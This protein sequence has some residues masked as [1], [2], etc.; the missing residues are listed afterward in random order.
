MFFAVGFETTAP[1]NAMA[2]QRAAALGV[3]NFAVI[4]AHVLVPPALEALLSCPGGRIQGLL[5]PGHVC[6]VTG[7]RDYEPLFFP[8]GDIGSLAVH[9]TVNDLAM[10]GATPLFLSAGFVLEDGLPIADLQRVVASMTRASA[11]VGTPIV[12]GDTK[13][14]DKGKGH[15]IFINTAGIGRIRQGVTVGRDGPSRET[16]CSCPARWAI[17]GSR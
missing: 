7:Y 5:A 3:D 14:V 8:G 12:T 1:A 13:V 16:P 6:A 17:T 15:G 2:V 4:V 10:C 11:A 9:G